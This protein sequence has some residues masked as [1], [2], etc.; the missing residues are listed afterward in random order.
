MRNNPT[1]ALNVLIVAAFAAVPASAQLSDEPDFDAC[2]VLVQGAECVLFTGGGG[3]YILSDYGDYRV[4]DLVRVIGTL[5]EGCITICQE[6]DGCIRGAEVFD[7]AIFPCGTPVRVE[8]D[9]CGGLSTALV[10]LL[11]GG[12]L[13]VGFRRSAGSN[14]IRQRRWRGSL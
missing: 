2:G 5:D 13:L 1:I 8:F 9:P 12:L 6:G 4:G 10:P 14:R 11:G 3:S 7:P